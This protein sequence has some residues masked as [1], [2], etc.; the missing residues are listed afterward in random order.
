ML[1]D[2]EVITVEAPILEFPRYI[3]LVPVEGAV[4]FMDRLKDEIDLDLVGPNQI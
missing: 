3:N 2:F 1:D 4:G